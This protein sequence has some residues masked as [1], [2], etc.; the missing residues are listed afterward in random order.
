MKF[1]ISLILI[2]LLSFAACLYFPWW[3][4]AIVSFIVVAVIPQ[5][6]GRAFLCGFLS[7]FILWSAL[8]FS[9]SNSNGHV[10]AHRMSLLIIKTDSPILL[11]FVTGLIG[12]I[13]AGLAGL[14]SSLLRKN[15]VR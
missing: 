7:L 10:L 11:I 8:S 5:R 1:F 6:P 9:F 2:A 14:T 3:S 13:I 12:A 4:I 15:P